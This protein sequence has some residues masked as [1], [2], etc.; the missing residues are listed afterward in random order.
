[1]G[2]PYV[3]VCMPDP[4]IEIQQYSEEEEPADDRV[5]LALRIMLTFLIRRWILF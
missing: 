5:Y 1:M 3:F 4:D 2:Q